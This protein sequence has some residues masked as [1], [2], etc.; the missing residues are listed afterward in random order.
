MFEVDPNLTHYFGNYY[1]FFDDT[2]HAHHSVSCQI[3][4][5]IEKYIHVGA[6]SRQ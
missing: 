4:E 6:L 2:A 1:Y 5:C 3:V